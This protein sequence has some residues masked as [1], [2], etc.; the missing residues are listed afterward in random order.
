M[1]RVVG[2]NGG[3]AAALM[4]LPALLAAQSTSN[5]LGDAFEFERRGN[6]EVA[7]Q[8]Y[9][10]ILKRSPANLSALLGLERV[11][12]PIGKLDSIMPYLDSALVLQPQNRSVR[13]L[14]IRVWILP[15]ETIT[16]E[17]DLTAAPGQ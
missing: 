4:V 13:S 14:Q 10:D 11:L 15:D 1:N 16:Y 12:L 6:Y 17:D 7:A 3:V 9:G 8:H 5:D 2:R